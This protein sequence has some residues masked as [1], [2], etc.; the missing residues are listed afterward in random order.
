MMTL[1][2]GEGGYENQEVIHDSAGTFVEDPNS[3]GL[4]VPEAYA[5]QKAQQAPEQTADQ[6]ITDAEPAPNA[7]D[8]PAEPVVEEAAQAT[9]EQV[10]QSDQAQKEAEATTT[11]ETTVE[12]QTTEERAEKVQELLTELEGNPILDTK[13]EDLDAELTKQAAESGEDPEK[14][15]GRVEKWWERVSALV[16]MTVG[17]LK[18]AQSGSSLQTFLAAFLVFGTEGRFGSAANLR[19]SFEQGSDDAYLFEELEKGGPEVLIEFFNDA[20]DRTNVQNLDNV[21]DLVRQF[22]SRAIMDWESQQKD[23]SDFLNNQKNQYQERS[24]NKIK[25]FFDRLEG[26]TTEKILEQFNIKEEKS[27]ANPADNQEVTA[28]ANQPGENAPISAQTQ[29]QAT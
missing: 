15:P 21:K 7:A 20:L 14:A 5:R 10:A 19:K 17:E 11:A 18:V 25:M 4:I 3:G 26:L 16:G 24:F 2:I 6:G 27:E 13:I 8:L 22:N 9:T 1:G 23:I 28:N 12:P 29:E